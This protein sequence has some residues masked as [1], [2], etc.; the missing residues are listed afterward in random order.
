M[1]ERGRIPVAYP[2]GEFIDNT[3]ADRQAIR[4]SMVAAEPPATDRDR[5]SPVGGL[6]HHPVTRMARLGR[7]YR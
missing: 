6:Q 7:S 3:L 5:N 1:T 4:S 2:G